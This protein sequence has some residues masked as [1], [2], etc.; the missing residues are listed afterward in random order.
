VIVFEQ[1]LSVLPVL[2]PFNTVLHVVVT[3]TINFF[4][5]TS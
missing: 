5:A 3:P 1:W 4:V 2:P